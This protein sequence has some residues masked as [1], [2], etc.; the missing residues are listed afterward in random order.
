[1]PDIPEMALNAFSDING[2]EIHS[3][4]QRQLLCVALCPS[5]G[6]EAYRMANYAELSKREAKAHEAQAPAADNRGHMTSSATKQTGS[7]VSS[8][9]AD[10]IAV[11]RELFPD[12]SDAEIDKLYKRIK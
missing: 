3:F 2:P 8:I 6:S 4:R 11:A 7:E 10:E 12:L 5:G 1:M 9:P